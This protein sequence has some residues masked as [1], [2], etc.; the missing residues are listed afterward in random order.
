MPLPLKMADSVGES[1][2]DALALID[3]VPLDVGVLE[4]LSEGV[5]VA[6]ARGVVV[7]LPLRTAESEGESEADAL[8]LIEVVLLVVD[9][10]ETLS[11]GVCVAEVRE[12]ALPLPLIE[13][14]PEL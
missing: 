11:E 10:P 3:A 12:V 13:V 6:E 4:M 9:V 1:V 5:W 8:A 7:Q 2:A 14:V